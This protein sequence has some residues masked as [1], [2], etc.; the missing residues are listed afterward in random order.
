MLIRL[1]K[2]TFYVFIAINWLFSST[3]HTNNTVIPADHLMSDMELLVSLKPDI[4]ELKRVYKLRDAGELNIAVRELAQ[5]YKN[6]LSERYYFNWENF[7]ERQDEYI[8]FYPNSQT[9]H[10]AGA[11]YFLSTY[12]R[13][14]KWIL[15]FNNL[16]GEQVTPYQLRH[17]ARQSWA[18]DIAMTFAFS[19]DSD[20]LEYMLGQVAS[21]NQAFGVGAYDD[22]GNGVYESFR[23]GKRIHHWLFSHNVF[24]ASE[25][26]SDHDQILMIKTFLHHGAQLQVRTKKNRYGN[27]H[28]KGLVALF[29]IAVLFSEFGT[30][31]VWLKQALEGLEW[32]ITNEINS[33]G[34]QFERSVHY[35]IGDIENYFRVYQLAH[36]NGIELPTIFRE[37]FYLMFE[38]LTKLAQPNKRL[39]VLQ[40]DTDV[41]FA[42]NNNITDA[43][44][45]GTIL[46]DDSNFDYFIN[47]KI[48]NE[49]YWLC[50]ED[51]LAVIKSQTD[52][53]PVFGSVALPCTGYYTMRNGW[54]N[55]SEYLTI[56]AGV[57]ERKPD[58]Q[59]GDILG[60]V[61]WANGHEILPNYQVKYSYPDYPQWKNSW[62]KNVALVDSI[63]LGRDWKSNR[64]GSGFGKW[65]TLPD[66]IVLRW[67]TN[68]KFDYFLGSHNGFVDIGVDYYREIIFFMDGF[69]LIRDY[70]Q[71]ADTHHYQQVWQGKYKT[72]AGPYL[73]KDYS[74]GSGVLILQYNDAAEYQNRPGRIGP[75]KHMTVEVMKNGDFIFSTMV[76]PFSDST[77]LDQLTGKNVFS[78]KLISNSDNLMLGSKEITSDAK[79]KLV[80]SD[81]VGF[82]FDLTWVK[83]GNR[84]VKFSN[85]V[86]MEMTSSQGMWNINMLGPA[87]GSY[88]ISRLESSGKQDFDPTKKDN[89]FYSGDKIKLVW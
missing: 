29:E 23:A 56:T 59:H 71:S 4:T 80:Q 31:E 28:T 86:S 36:R 72:I 34:F 82:L 79:I 51:Q 87:D 67:E 60:V 42:E 50:S 61:A 13:Q 65:S 7:S 27:H 63:P 2:I 3:R 21:L 41:R 48:S 74:D 81:E 15:P 62:A 49:R 78:W 64:G 38:A 33:D 75:K 8:S 89:Y 57:S 83:K 43:M 88:S 16:K 53:T 70:F 20:L 5:Y 24:L 76:I 30:A 73:R 1:L 18:M 66:P 85:S 14:P 37:R 12:P 52:V 54:Y 58:H 17:L 84:M 47:G 22:A 32:H 26:Y 55:N 45:F 10:K 77:E 40:D 9:R 46:F 35:H 19:A 39:P 6:K 68:Q 44:I 69:W 25:L 11:D